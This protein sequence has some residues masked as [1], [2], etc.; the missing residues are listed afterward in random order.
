MARPQCN[1]TID[2]IEREIDDDDDDDEDED[3]C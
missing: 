2:N 3:F 1:T